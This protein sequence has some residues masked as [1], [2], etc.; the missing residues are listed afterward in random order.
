MKILASIGCLFLAIAVNGQIE[1]LKGKSTEEPCYAKRDKLRN[2]QFGGWECGKLAGVVDCNAELDYDQESGLILKKAMNN[3]DLTGVGKPFTGQC[4]TCY[5]SGVLERRI[6]FVDGRENGT[7]TTYYESGCPQ[8]VRTHIQ[9]EESGTWTYFYDSTQQVAWEM[10]YYLGE[11]NGR[12]VYMK[13]NG[14][15]TKVETYKNGLLHG[16]RKS[17]YKD[18][19]I[20]KEASYANGI[21]DGTFKT[22][23]K[24]GLVI[25]EL[26]YKAGEKNGSCKYYYDDGVLLKTENWEMGVKNGE[27]KMFYYQ[28]HVQT[29][30]TYK[31]GVKYGKFEEYY[32]NQKPKRLAVYEKDE[33]IEEHLFDELGNETYSFGAPISSGDEDDAIRKKGKKKE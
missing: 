21:L 20:Y 1:S 6:S 18:S 19:K 7:D 3:A 13:A 32:P 28:G 25:E 22:Y 9:G 33:L 16:V 5:M 23:N 15:T 10:N 11:K 8:V 2:D 12:Q 14:D 30:E 24:E 31:K 29:L 26:N 27:F 17:Y 4:E